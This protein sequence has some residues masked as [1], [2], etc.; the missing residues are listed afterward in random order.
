[1]KNYVRCFFV[2][3]LLIGTHAMKS[4]NV[5]IG[6][7]SPDSSALLD[8]FTKTNKP[9]GLLTPRLTQ[10]EINSFTT[11]NGSS[12]ALG[13]LVFNVTTKSFWYFNSTSW[14]EF[15]N[16]QN[17]PYT[18]PSMDGTNGQVLTTNGSGVI[19]F[20]DSP[21]DNLG[22]HKATQNIEL[23]NSWLSNDADNEGISVSNL[24]WVGVNTSA[25]DCDLTVSSGL[26]ESG[27][28]LQ[29]KD[30]SFT[31][32]LRFQNSG[33]NYTWNFY[34]TETA[35]LRLAGGLSKALLSDL[36]DRMTFLS[37]GN[38]GINTTNPSSNLE[39]EG[40][41]LF[42]GTSE[43]LYPVGSNDQ[44][45]MI[46]GWLEAGTTGNLSNTTGVT[47]TGS[48]TGTNKIYTINYSAAGFSSPPVFVGNARLDP[49]S[50]NVRVISVVS[51]TNNAVQ[52]QVK[53]GGGTKQTDTDVI[54]MIL[55]KR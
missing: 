42:G 7:S 45:L 11:L 6:T 35:D 25:P 36:P 46:S 52:F 28:T 18:W 22:D 54:F 15:A 29:V 23:N 14:I 13:L 19:S 40:E 32:G 9:F 10:G 43:D 31:Q 37:N 55:G 26:T 44:M 47:L 27:I 12:P 1:M 50:S 21:F 49:G 4:Q 48:Y 51:I 30:N 8:L 33:G 24:G 53:N 2:G 20:T 38:V 41:I 17:L 34:R 5:G 39:V 16:Q 3:V